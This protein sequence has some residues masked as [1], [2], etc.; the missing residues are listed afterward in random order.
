M[1]SKHLREDFA[2][3]ILFARFRVGKHALGR[4]NDGDTEAVADARQLLGTRIDAAARLRD[5][6]DVLDRGLAF[7]ILQFDAQRRS[8]VP[9][10]SS[11]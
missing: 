3:D 1:A 6:R 10:S 2:A 7:E 11:E 9:P 5:A 4:R 8:G